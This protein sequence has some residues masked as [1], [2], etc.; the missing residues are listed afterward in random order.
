MQPPQSRPEQHHQSI[1]ESLADMLVQEAFTSIGHK[2]V[3]SRRVAPITNPL[4][5]PWNAAFR[6]QLD[7][8]HLFEQ[9]LAKLGGEYV[10]QNQVRERL[11]HYICLRG[12]TQQ[13]RPIEGPGGGTDSIPL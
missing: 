13:G 3:C 12:L 11:N 1:E 8:W 6:Q 9:L 4:V 2:P 7:R 5:I 10:A